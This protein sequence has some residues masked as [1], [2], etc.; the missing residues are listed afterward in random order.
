MLKYVS[1][2][3]SVCVDFNKISCFKILLNYLVICIKKLYDMKF[4]FVVV[5]LF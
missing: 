4:L 5:F 1:K 2:W 3:F